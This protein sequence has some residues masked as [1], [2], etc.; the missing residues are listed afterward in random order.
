M[1]VEFEIYNLGIDD[2]LHLLLSHFSLCC[3]LYN[4]Y[5]EHEKA[6]MS[7]KTSCF[8]EDVKNFCHSG[9]QEVRYKQVQTRSL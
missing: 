2:I 1:R 4:V 3:V 9:S 7:L 8:N 5:V 6:L